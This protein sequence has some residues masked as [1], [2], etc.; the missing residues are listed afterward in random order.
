MLALSFWRVI[1]IGFVNFWRNIW[2]SLASTL[3]LSVTLV[4]FATLLVVFSLTNFALGSVKDKVDVSAYFKSTV[5]EAQILA[6]QAEVIALPEV[7]DTDYV[8]RAEALTLFKDTHKNDTEILN[9]LEEVGENPLQAVLRVRAKELSQF[10]KI[11][12]LLSS[13]K[14]KPYIQ[15][16]NFDDNRLLI[17]RLRTIMDFIVMFGGAVA[18]L[19][20]LIAI[21]VIF[22]TI[23]LTIYNRKDEVEIMRL[24]GATNWYIR[25]QFLVEALVYC[26]IATLAVSVALFIFKSEF[27]ATLSAYLGTDNA[28]LDSQILNLAYVVP[29]LFAVAFVLS[30]VSSFMS[31]RKY[32]KI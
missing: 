3:I 31:I 20:S 10:P 24:V 32:L 21:L 13:E 11:A 12:E 4:I 18:I 7:L 19:F 6:V 23:T 29:A 1:K 9:A 14:Y 5:T 26:V 27:G 30:V 16:V 15:S 17:E 22:N 8:S 2:L 25:G 28:V